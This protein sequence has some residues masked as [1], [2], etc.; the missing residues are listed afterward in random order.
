MSRKVLVI[1]SKS[2]FDGS[3]IKD[4]LDMTLIY[5]A[6]D[7]QVSWLF[8]DSAVLALQTNLDAPSL[9]LKDV[10]KQ[11]KTL[12]IYDV[13]QVYA[14]QSAMI[15][16]NLSPNLLAID[17]DIKDQQEISALIKQHDFVVTI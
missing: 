15:E 4:A 14:C 10:F 1:S 5:A 9:G 12:E 16:F 2:P 6:V 17:V 13:D 11:L 3:A 8:I 7:Q